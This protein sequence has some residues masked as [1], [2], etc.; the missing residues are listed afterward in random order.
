ML[1][2]VGGNS[3][4]IGKTAVAAAIIAALPQ[5]RWQA[6]K[7]TQHGHHICSPTGEPCDC[8]PGDA[9]HPYALD[10]Q[11][12]ADATDSGRFLAAGAVR[13]WWLR[14][15]AGELGH[16]LPALRK[17]LDEHAY[18][19]VESNSLLRFIRPDLYLMV[20]DFSV[21]DIKDSA[22]LYMDRADAFVLTSTGVAPWPHVP[23]RWFEMKPC[24]P[25]APPRYMTPELVEFIR[26]RLSIP[27]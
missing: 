14:T 27:R 5:A 4:N 15:A 9:L 8:D 7:I 18:T 12:I 23:R 10:E 24:F 11:K 21:A 26:G 6:I 3:R 17:L 1:L 22:R 20:L 2:A 13:S 16:A 19:I 25:V